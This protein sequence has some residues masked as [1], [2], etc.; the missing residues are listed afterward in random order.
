MGIDN[1]GY[2]DALSAQSAADFAISKNPALTAELK[3]NNEALTLLPAM[4][5]AGIESSLIK[6]ALDIHVN[7]ALGAHEKL[8]AQDPMVVLTT[9]LSE[10]ATTATDR[11]AVQ[12]AVKDMLATRADYVEQRT[13]GS[14]PESISQRQ[15]G[16]IITGAENGPISEQMILSM[17]RK[18]GVIRQDE[19]LDAL[20]QDFAREGVKGEYNGADNYTGFDVGAGPINKGRVKHN[21]NNPTIALY[22]SPQHLEAFAANPDAFS[23]GTAD[24]IINNDQEMQVIP[25]SKEVGPD[26]DNIKYI[27]EELAK[28]P[29]AWSEITGPDGK[30]A[31]FG[32]IVSPSKGMANGPSDFTLMIGP[33]GPALFAYRAS[34]F[35]ANPVPYNITQ[36]SFSRFSPEQQKR[37][38]TPYRLGAGFG[39][40]EYSLAD[41]KNNKN[42][43]M[44]I[45]SD[46]RSHTRIDVYPFKGE[47][48]SRLAAI[49][50]Q[51]MQSLNAA[52]LHFRP[53]N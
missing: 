36:E 8:I 41:A 15:W 31:I 43:E 50:P 9:F 27:K 42:P 13:Y 40:D 39:Q 2:V 38:F 18:L 53:K 44:N 48:L 25:A 22:F 28:R 7:E 3:A 52:E 51:V 21:P 30:I 6:S 11:L 1:S 5:K 19:G 17:M 33:E 47:D 29:N 45:V 26:V 16:V 34:I 20:K 49:Y 37:M 23:R 12:K 32:R 46:Q 35:D 4:K 10:S 14:N 24:A